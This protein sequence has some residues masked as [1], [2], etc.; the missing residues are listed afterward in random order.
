MAEGMT[1]HM[2]RRSMA[3]ALVLAAGFAALGGSAWAQGEKVAVITP[4]LA[5]PGTQFYVEAFQARAK[6]R[7]RGTKRTLE[8]EGNAISLLMPEAKR[9]SSGRIQN[10]IRKSFRAEKSD[11]TS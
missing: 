7:Q 5:Q 1:R 9:L 10:I 11:P 3:R 2:T 4:Y 6:E 8:F